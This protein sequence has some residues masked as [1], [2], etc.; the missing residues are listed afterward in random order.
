MISKW[1]KRQ[2][3]NGC[4]LD[5]IRKNIVPIHTRSIHYLIGFDWGLQGNACKILFLN[6]NSV[7]LPLWKHCTSISQSRWYLLKWK[8]KLFSTST[9]CT[10][11]TNHHYVWIYTSTMWHVPY[12][13]TWIILYKWSII[14]LYQTMQHVQ[15]GLL[16]L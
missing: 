9:T 14:N 7:V 5:L 8:V 4:Y 15:K 13:S 6:H 16:H 11:C 2:S 10:C 1:I 3:L 12:Q